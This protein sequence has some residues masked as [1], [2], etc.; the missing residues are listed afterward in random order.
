MSN[1]PRGALIPEETEPQGDHCRS[2]RALPG[3][4]AAIVAATTSDPRKESMHQHQA[5]RWISEPRFAPFL[6]VSGNYRD[7]VALYVWNAQLAAACLETL[8]HLEVL[9]RNSVD[10]C[11]T[12]TDHWADVSETWLANSSLLNPQSIRRVD[13]AIDRIRSEGKASTRGR[14]VSSVSFGFW[15][16]LLSRKY[17]R[18]WVSHIHHAFPNGSGNRSEIAALMSRLNPFRNRIAH[19]ESLIGQD[20]G[21]RHEEMIQLAGMIDAGAASWIRGHSRVYALLEMEPTI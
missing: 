7:A 4:F 5:R 1:R 2:R 3:A 12:P 14:V 9:M 15:R 21:L 17:D 8:H 16:A 10:F 13:E 11:F 6:A 20:V 19:H 18:L